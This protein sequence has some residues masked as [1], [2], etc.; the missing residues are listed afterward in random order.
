MT[1]FPEYG[2]YDALGLA[3]LV[4]SK[5]VTP[6]ELLE[7]SI[8]R[9]EELNP[10]VNAVID[11]LYDRARARAKNV[12]SE[13]AFAGVPFFLKDH[14]SMLAG[15]PTRSGSRFLGEW[16]PDRNSEIVN[17]YLATG[18]LVVGKTNSPE[19]GILPS[20]E[21][22]RFGPTRNPWDLTRTAG[23]S[24]GGSAAAVAAHMVP[25]AGG[26]DGGGSIRIPSSCCGIFGLKP[27]RGRTPVGPFEVEP[28]HGFSIEHVLTRSVRDSAAMLDAL[29]GPFLG[30]AHSL[31]IPEQPFLEEMGKAPGR[32]RIACSAEPLLPGRVHPECRAAFEETVALLGELGHET[33]EAAPAIDGRAFARSFLVM[34]AGHTWAAIR[35]AEERVGRKASRDDF[36]GKT[37][38]AHRM[39]EAFTAGEYVQAIGHLQQAGREV[40]AFCEGYD[41]LLS[42]TT[43]MPPPKLGFLESTG[44]QAVLE[45]I[46]LTL[47]VGKLMKRGA[48]LE[49]AA[50]DSFSFVPWTPVFNATG[51]PS[52]SVPLCWS[53]EGLPIGMM[54][55]ASQGDEATLFR[56]AA[57]LE[58]ARPWRDRIP[59][60]CV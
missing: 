51:Q 43:A 23:G 38:L 7:A 60:L 49:Q 30:D 42:P 18:A 2:S 28:W 8:T 27:T 46:A 54:F 6:A 35:V 40:L 9:I 52:M 41:L 59:P 36:E 3:E 39:G 44:F 31:P 21:P 57:Q 17:R 55:T 1:D 47:P 29:A 32:M 14:Q 10:K 15:V 24:S 34:I 26:G 13:G 20:T 12:P 45:K 58:E 16:R 19:L 11:K 50:A 5:Q 4:R 48:A 37:W 33:V 22:E 56:L 25:M 53:A